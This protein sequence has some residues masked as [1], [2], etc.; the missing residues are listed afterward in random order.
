MKRS[1]PWVALFLAGL[2]SA[3]ISACASDTAPTAPFVINP[4]PSATPTHATDTE[5]PV[6]ARD[7]ETPLPAQGATD[8]TETATPPPTEPSGYPAPTSPLNADDLG[9]LPDDPTELMFA[10]FDNSLADIGR[11]MAY[12]HND[13]FIPVLMEF[14][15]FQPS[16]EAQL[17]LVSF[18]VRIRDRIPE[19]SFAIV[20]QGEG[21]WG[22]WVQW[23]AEHPE[24]SP[25]PGFDG[26]KGQLFSIIDEPMGEFIY[27]GVPT[28]IRLEEIVWGGVRRDGI[29][30]LQFPPHISP[31]EATYL[32]TGDRV[33]GVSINGE[34]RAYP[35]RVLNAHEMANDT[36]GGVQF[37]LAY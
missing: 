35:L 29:P 28:T 4:S 20:P 8:A 1:I 33:F 37:A 10:I 23:V 6:P 15:R 12:S 3:S 9:H 11:K 36:V 2:I 13:A 16:E 27:A 19:G 25:P 30:D 21:N 22:W 14:L 34:H 7:A 17:T 24:A 18:M 31:E 26:W 32:E 5:N